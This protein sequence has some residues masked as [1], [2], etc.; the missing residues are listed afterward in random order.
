MKHL[1]ARYLER[2][3]VPV[4]G[5]GRTV[6]VVALSRE[7]RKLLDNTRMDRN[8]QALYSGFVKPRE[9]GHDAALYRVYLNRD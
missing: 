2:R 4:D 6:E 7:G 3:V 9:I 8:A 1:A 5:R